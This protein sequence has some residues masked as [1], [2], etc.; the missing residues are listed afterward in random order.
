MI[1]LMQKL[2]PHL[3]REIWVNSICASRLIPSQARFLFLRLAGLRLR[4]CTVLHGVEWFGSGRVTFER[5]MTLNRGVVVN[6][7]GGLYMGENSGLGPGTL[8]ITATHEIGPAAKR[9]GDGTT[10]RV[11]V[12]RGA[13]V[14]ANVTILP[15]VRIGEGCIIGAGSVVAR[16]CRPHTVYVGVPARPVRS[17]EPVP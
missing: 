9:W 11:V 8:V 6:H 10:A 3:V 14:G 16:D 5:G 1:N 7:S 13:W 12:G 15:G 17:L 2:W 4:R